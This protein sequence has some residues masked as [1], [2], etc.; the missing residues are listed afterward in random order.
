MEVI[1][2]Q[3]VENNFRLG[4]VESRAAAR[5]K[6]LL[7]QELSPYDRDCLTYSPDSR[8]IH[9]TDVGKRDWA[10]SRALNPIVPCHLDPFQ[11]HQFRFR[12]CH[13]TY[14]R[15]HILRRRLPVSGDALHQQEI[16][17]RWGFRVMAQVVGEFRGRT[18]TASSPVA[19]PV[20]VPPGTFWSVV[21]YTEK[22]QPVPL[23]ISWQFWVLP[24]E[25]SFRT[26]SFR[27]VAFDALL[28]Y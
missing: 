28:R 7:E 11:Q 4:S 19:L 17:K 13:E 21:G 14:M 3:H 6:L 15:F 25:L 20:E 18:G 2:A 1:C 12:R 10:I 27:A 9:E 22:R 16:E 8:D 26:V 24:K 23:P 5:R